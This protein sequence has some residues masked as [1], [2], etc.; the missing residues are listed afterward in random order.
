VPLA[1]LVNKRV[2]LPGK[3]VALCL[4]RQH[5]RQNLVSR[6]I[7]RGLVKDGRSCAWP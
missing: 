3:T 6:I 5:R 1:A 4:G 2:A 7:E